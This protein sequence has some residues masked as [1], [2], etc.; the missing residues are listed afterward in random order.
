MKSEKHPESLV[1]VVLVELPVVSDSEVEADSLTKEIDCADTVVTG[2]CSVDA[3]LGQRRPVDDVE[4]TVVPFMVSHRPHEQRV[5][6]ALV[7]H[8]AHARAEP[9]VVHLTVDLVSTRECRV[10]L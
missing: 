7:W 3:L 2:P 1:G 8:K 6:V 4:L 10:R 9:D 5:A